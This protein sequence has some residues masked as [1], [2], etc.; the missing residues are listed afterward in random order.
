[1]RLFF[2]GIISVI[3]LFVLSC[4]NDSNPVDNNFGKIRG[5]VIN[6]A[7]NIVSGVELYT[8]PPTEVKI[9]DNNGEFIF[10]SVLS[11][12]YIVNAKK[13][14]FATKSISI[15]V[16][17]GK[18]SEATIVLEETP[19]DN[20]VPNNPI[21]ITPNNKSIL[22]TPVNFK[23][24]CIDPDGDILYYD[25]Y[26]GI[27]ID[28]LS[29]H[30]ENLT[31]NEIII[32]ELVFD[33]TYYWRIVAK[34]KWGAQSKSEIRSFKYI[35]FINDSKLLMFLPFDGDIRDLSKYNQNT[36]NYFVSFVNDR[37]GNSNSAAYFDGNLS[38]IQISSPNE[39]DFNK[40]F[41]ISLWAKP[42]VGYGSLYDSEVDLIGRYGA[43][44]SNTSSF[45]LSIKDSY[46]KTEIYQHGQGRSVLITDKIIPINLW[47]HIALVNN[48]GILKLYLNG[49]LV[50][51]SNTGNPDKSNLPLLIGKRITQNRIF[52]GAMDDIK[53]Y[54]YACTDSEVKSLFQ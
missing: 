34:D 41:T 40:P 2:K 5:K 42:D 35:N 6:K 23:W 37:F 18:T 10:V 31:T 30:S 54:N 9:S 53:I 8:N 43:A 47:S 11:G 38:N 39:M 4:G 3:L 51:S 48:S 49:E 25:F 32:N 7:G 46:L 13:D 21:L 20:N 27:K 19:N 44:S 12:T 26:I 22:T 15:S 29:I 16:L 52:K 14:G 36:E 45:A 24:E 1:M 17:S 50:G 28:S 33:N